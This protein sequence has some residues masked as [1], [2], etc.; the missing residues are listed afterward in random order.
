M[1]VQGLILKTNPIK[2]LCYQYTD[3]D[4]Q[5]SA[6]SSNLVNSAKQT[7]HHVICSYYLCMVIT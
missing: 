6:L 4:T 2:I 3:Y 5:I 7:I 1:D